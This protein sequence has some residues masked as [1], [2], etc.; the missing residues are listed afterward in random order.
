MTISYFLLASLDLLGTLNEVT[1]EVEREG[2][3]QWVWD[4]QLR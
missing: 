2:W 4:Q 3:I 1:T